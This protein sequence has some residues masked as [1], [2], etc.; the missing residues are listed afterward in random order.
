MLRDLL[1]QKSLSMMWAHHTLQL[2][3]S[4]SA[5]N[6]QLQNAKFNAQIVFATYAMITFSQ[7]LR[8]FVAK[9]YL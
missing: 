4:I 9:N 6:W 8:P 7:T 3:Y 2:F 5:L 1:T